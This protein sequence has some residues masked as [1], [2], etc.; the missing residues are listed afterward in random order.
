MAPAKLPRMMSNHAIQR[1]AIAVAMFDAGWPVPDLQLVD[2]EADDARGWLGKALVDLERVPL[3]ER[4]AEAAVGLRLLLVY[5]LA[6]ARLR[7]L[8]D[9]GLEGDVLD[10][11]LYV[12]SYLPGATPAA[13]LAATID[14]VG[15]W[16]ASPIVQ[17]AVRVVA[18]D[19]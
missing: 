5:V 1:A 15:A 7:G 16:L 14:A 11:A 2:R 17:D 3:E 8:P 9:A 18:E 4:P 19:L 6:P 12:A 10:S 13:T